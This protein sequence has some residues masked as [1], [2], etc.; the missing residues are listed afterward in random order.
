MNMS[1]GKDRWDED[2]GIP[3]E[4]LIEVV[5]REGLMKE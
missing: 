2:Y 3:L 4:R 1:R 5:V